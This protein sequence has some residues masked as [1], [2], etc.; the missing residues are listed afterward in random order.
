MRGDKRKR[1]DSYDDTVSQRGSMNPIGDESRK[2][3][4]LIVGLSALTIV[5]VM[6]S[7]FYFFTS[8]LPD[9]L[10]LAK[11]SRVNA[12]VQDEHESDDP[13]LT[14]ATVP[15]VVLQVD[16][17]TAM[18]YLEKMDN[19]TIDGLLG[20]VIGGNSTTGVKNVDDSSKSLEAAY[21]EAEAKYPG[22]INASKRLQL[23]NEL[24]AKD[25]SITLP[26]MVI[27]YWLLVLRLASL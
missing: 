11:M 3:S 18:A 17:E 7:L 24:N 14:V 5:G 20:K 22:Q 6:V 9:T 21:A 19:A 15:G 23:I 10:Y 26:K 16:R 2:T 12:Q 8:D 1:L 27:R 13:G 25:Y 4:R